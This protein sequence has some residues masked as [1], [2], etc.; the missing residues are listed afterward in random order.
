MATSPRPILMSWLRNEFRRSYDYMCALA[1][2]SL[3][4]MR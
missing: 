2:K 3:T 4:A 1:A